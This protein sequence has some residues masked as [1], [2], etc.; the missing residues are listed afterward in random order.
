MRPPS[1]PLAGRPRFHRKAAYTRCLRCAGAPRRPAS[2]SALSLHMPSSLTSGSSIIVP[3]QKCRRW[4]S[5]W[6]KGLGSPNSPAI[7]F[8]RGT[9]FAATLVRNCYGLSGCWPPCTDLTGLPATRG[10][11]FQAFDGSVTLPVAGYNYNSVW[12]PLL[13]GLPPAGMAASLAALVRPCSCP[14]TD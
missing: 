4:P 5:L 2:G 12:T 7:R 14:A 11:C 8:T 6:T 9:V 1:V 3:V 13:A 10:L